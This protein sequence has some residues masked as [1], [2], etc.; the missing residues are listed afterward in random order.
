AAEL[1]KIR[2]VIEKYLLQPEKFRG[3]YG[4]PSVAFDDRSYN[5][6]KDGYYW[7]GQIWMINNYTA[8]EVLFRFGYCREALELH[9]RVIRT[10]Y[11]SAGL[12]ETYNAENGKIG[13]SSRGPG[14]QAVMQFG[15]SSAWAIQIASCRYQHFRYIFPDTGELSGHIR[16]ADTFDSVPAFSPPSVEAGPYHAL[17]QIR[18]TG[19]NSHCVPHINLKSIDGKPLLDAQKIQVLFEV[20]GGSIKNK[21]EIEFTWR[22]CSYRLQPNK[23]YLIGLENGSGRLSS[24]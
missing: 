19:G 20:P 5:H 8:L 17:M 13:W 14:D 16:W 23:E 18:V 10:L 4:I 9:K 7:R 2:T 1:Q 24:V 6:R 15:M 11:A 22:D 12:Y 21:G 3:E